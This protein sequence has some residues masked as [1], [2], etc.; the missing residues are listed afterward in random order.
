MI[1]KKSLPSFCCHSSSDS[2]GGSVLWCGVLSSKPP[3]IH[4]LL[5]STELI[6]ILLLILLLVPNL[7]L[8]LLLLL[9]QIYLLV[10]LLLSR[11][12]MLP[13]I[14][15]V[16]L[17]L[18]MTPLPILILLLI[19]LPLL[20]FFFFPP[21]FAPAAV[22]DSILN[23]GEISVLAFETLMK[24]LGLSEQEQIV[25][26]SDNR[27]HRRSAHSFLVIFLS[28]SVVPLKSWCCRREVILS[29]TSEVEMTRWEFKLINSWIPVN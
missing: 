13:L 11:F 23:P 18:L 26:E 9:I 7:L 28:V 2:R 12:T 16:I 19:L 6:Q 20:L 29:V 4:I 24:C 25:L 10:I 17:I 1:W 21:N 22:S 5:Q 8:I 3:W 15:T 27:Q 14:L